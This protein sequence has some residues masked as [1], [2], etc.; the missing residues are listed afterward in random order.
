MLLAGL[1]FRQNRGSTKRNRTTVFKNVLSQSWT[2]NPSNESIKRGDRELS[3]ILPPPP[4]LFPEPP[5]LRFISSA[6]FRLG[7]FKAEHVPLEDELEALC[8][9]HTARADLILSGDLSCFLR[10]ATTV[11]AFT[12]RENDD[13]DDEEGKEEEEGDSS[14][15]SPPP[16]MFSSIATRDDGVGAASGTGVA[17]QGE[18]TAADPR[19]RRLEALENCMDAFE[20]LVTVRFTLRSVM[21][22]ID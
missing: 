21:C 18:E 16:A 6:A 14:Y 10:V 3:L 20:R 4:P 5:L 2:N 9:L 13:S 19:Q 17:G 11:E 8:S 22:T 12:F 7:I 1:R 15:F